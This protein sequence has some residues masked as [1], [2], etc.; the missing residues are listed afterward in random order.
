MTRCIRLAGIVAILFAC[1]DSARGQDQRVLISDPLPEGTTAR[2]GI[3]QPEG[4]ET[5]FAGG[6]TDKGALIVASAFG[7]DIHVRAWQPAKLPAPATRLLGHKA[8]IVRMVFAGDAASLAVADE[9]GALK[10][11]DV[12]TGKVRFATELGGPVTALALD[13]KGEYLIAG[14][15][16]GATI[17]K[18]GQ[19]KAVNLQGQL[20]TIT[21]ATFA[22][23]GKHVATGDAQGN[24]RL[25]LM[26]SG[27]LKDTLPFNPLPNVEPKDP[28]L[29]KFGLLIGGANPIP[30]GFKYVLEFGDKGVQHVR[31]A[32]NGKALAAAGGTVIRSWDLAQ[33]KV[34]WQ[35]NAHAHIHQPGTPSLGPIG[36]PV[37]SGGVSDLQYS[38][39][40]AQVVSS[41]TYSRL[42]F[43]DAAT[44]KQN[45]LH[46]VSG[47]YYSRA[48]A[49][50][51]PGGKTYFVFRAGRDFREYDVQSGKE[52][53]TAGAHA[54]AIL[55]LAFA[56]DG[57]TLASG[58]NK[59]IRLWDLG[60]Q[61]LQSEADAMYDSH[62]G[63]AFSPD[64]KFLKSGKHYMDRFQVWQV[65]D[66]G[67]EL[68]PWKE[69]H[70]FSSD[71]S[72]FVPSQPATL[73]TLPHSA[74]MR[75]ITLPGGDE[76]VFGGQ[77]SHLG[78]IGSLS[79]APDGKSFAVG[80]EYG[81]GPVLLST[82]DGKEV[83][84][85]EGPAYSDLIAFS[86]D[87]RLIAAAGYYGDKASP[88]QLWDAATGRRYL[89]LTGHTKQVTSLA[90][91]ADG[92]LLVSASV[93]QKVCLW[94]LATGKL[95]RTISTSVQRGAPSAAFAPKE[96]LLATGGVDG[97]VL[98][99]DVKKERSAA[100]PL[101]KELGQG[102]AP[103]TETGMWHKRIPM[104][105]RPGGLAF[106]PDGKTLAVGGQSV[107]HLLDPATGKEQKQLGK[108]KN[109]ISYLTYAR[110]GKFLASCGYYFDG[111]EGKEDSVRVW[112]PV[113]G[114][115]VFGHDKRRIMADKIAFTADG[116]ILFNL[117]SEVINSAGVTRAGVQAWRWQDK[118]AAPFL[119]VAPSWG[120]SF[121]VS[122]N[123]RWLLL[124]GG[125]SNELLVWDMDNDKEHLR[126][127]FGP[128]VNYF[129]QGLDFS[130]DGKRAAGVVGGT[131]YL[132]D[133]ET[134]KEIATQPVKGHVA[135]LVFSP[136]GRWLATVGEPNVGGGDGVRIWDARTG[137]YLLGLRGHGNQVAWSRDGRWL[138][139]ADIHVHEPREQAVLIWDVAFLTGQ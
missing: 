70:S 36:P 43:A 31:F 74:N 99:W 130:P 65:L 29:G 30:P 102:L 71:A 35:L 73:I 15:K 136:C 82:T 11:W 132:W 64:G 60:T 58:G 37:Q 41:D 105:T 114:E 106:A 38:R 122:P 51:A 53:A 69:L 55:S 39:D 95:L 127:K 10:V 59:Q 129:M 62:P 118:P 83:R 16:Q 21:A 139:S 81:K 93:D 50:F 28:P 66:G 98:L 1:A 86:P 61:S 4:Q 119:K 124:A 24:V 45:R 80:M 101:P 48:G 17:W 32:P 33:R 13:G 56:L 134:W 27:E 88:V 103:G 133:A 96:M 111:A 89:D 2:F 79:A 78:Y 91:S 128:E 126:K 67:K 40:G 112:D 7:A 44:G 104:P 109:K 113:R 57:K 107:I 116:K 120:G 63:L 52:V 14:G 23:N 84:K 54:G 108:F 25:W 117:T 135:D 5:A 115:V 77:I 92:R 20:G 85:L 137:Q 131:L 125:A 3:A 22:P 100:R 47:Y 97:T 90:F 123:G 26:A 8:K 72:D 76:K 94:E 46:A 68:T 9:G 110:D 42:R 18:I 87:G 75:T 6:C 19:D 138:A 12:F 49:A 121:A 34:L